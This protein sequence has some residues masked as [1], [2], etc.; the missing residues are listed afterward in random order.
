MNEMLLEPLKFYEHSGKATHEKNTSDYFDELVAK[1]GIDVEANRATVAAYRKQ[2]EAV[3]AAEDKVSKYKTYKT[4]LIIGIIIGAII[5]IWSFWKFGD[6]AGSATAMLLGGAAAIVI[7]VL[8]LKNVVNP[9]IKD[10]SAHLEILRKK[11]EKIKAEAQAQ[12]APLNALF[13]SQDTFRLIEKTMPEFSFDNR[14]TKE[15]EA[16]FIRLNDFVDL[17][18]NETTMVNTLA[19]R[20]AGNPF[21]YCQRL[22][23]EMGL[24]TYTGTLV[25]TWTETYYANGQRHT[26]TRSQTLCA[27]VTKPK[28][29]YYYNTYLGY[30]CQAAPELSYSREPQHWERCSERELEKKIKS[31]EKQLHKMTEKAVK[32]GKFFQEMDNVEFEVLYGAQNRDH[33]VQFRVMFTPLGQRNTIALLKNKVGYGDD[34][35]FTKSRRF[36]IIATEHAQNW[37]MSTSPTHYHSFDVDEA[38]RKFC[39]FNN[40]YFKS[41]FFDFAPI[42]SVPAYM[43][44]PCAAMEPIESFDCNQTCYE[45]EVM[46]NAIGQEYFVSPESATSAILKTRLVEKRGGEDVVSVSASSYATI[47]RVDI[48]PRLGGDGRIHGVPVHWIEYI[49]VSNSKIMSVKTEKQGNDTTPSGTTFHGLVADIM[50]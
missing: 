38:R 15:H 44:E 20:F 18:T 2:M 33:E 39:N 11:A 31:G 1:S 30:G 14:F 43:D 6:S 37:D 50:Q 26:R 45:H 46:A 28:P 16:Y 41:V 7:F 3:A 23:H 19:G 27:T 48:I 10:G 25:I 13:S 29:R 24:E 35:R 36:N 22:V 5:S 47:P 4:L 12:M 49:P 34:F 32:D 21:L 8:L 17:S 9:R 40:D 42:F